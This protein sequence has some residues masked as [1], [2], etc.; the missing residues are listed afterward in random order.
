MAN[1]MGFETPNLPTIDISGFLSSSWIYVAVVTL[2]GIIL[3]AGISI[4]LFFMT[5][6]KKVEVY[7]NISGM[8]YQRVLVTR[9]RL[10]KLGVGGEEILKTLVG[11]KYVSAYG[12]KMGRNTY[13]FAKGQDGYWYNSTLGDLDTKLAMLDIEPVDRDVRMF[14]F[15]LDKLSHQTYGKTGFLEKYGIH[16]ML[17]AFLIIMLVGFWIIA[18]KINE[19]LVA[20]NAAANINLKT[21]QAA[22]AALTKVDSVNRGGTSGLIPA[23]G[24]GGG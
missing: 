16:I 1:I 13:W 8:G 15:A 4:M 20:T 3:I 2:V 24:G 22:D 14:H 23:G 6:N 10:V 11:G 18:G 9:A 12:R 7:E 5:Y 17:F 21:V 19:G